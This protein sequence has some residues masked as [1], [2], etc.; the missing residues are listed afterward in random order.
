MVLAVLLVV[1]A[2]AAAQNTAPD[3]PDDPSPADNGDGF[4]SEIN[5]SVSVDDPDGDQLDVYFFENVTENLV[6]DGET[7]TIRDNI[8]FNEIILKS[9][10][11]LYIGDASTGDADTQVYADLVNFSEDSELHLES[12]SPGARLHLCQEENCM[13]PVG[14]HENVEPGG[15]AWAIVGGHDCDSSYD[16]YAT[17]SDGA[18]NSSSAVWSFNVDCN[19]LP[20]ASNPEPPDQGVAPGENTLSDVELSVY[21]SDPD[22]ADDTLTVYFHNAETDS[23]ID[24]TTI[25]EPG[26]AQ[27]VWEDLVLGETYNWFVNVSDG[28]ENFTS[29]SW[30]FQRVTSTGYRAETRIDYDYTSIITSTQ[31][32]AT[33]FIEVENFVDESKDLTTTLSVP[34]GGADPIFVETGTSTNSYTLPAESTRRMEVRIEPSSPGDKDLIV[35]TSND[36]LGITTRE[37]IPLYVRELPTIQSS[38]D[39][40]GIG[41]VHVIVLF[42]AAT[43]LFA[44]SL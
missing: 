11:E 26:T 37:S 29:S 28:K 24:S 12:E 13:K 30:E 3:Q 21:A 35:D 44:S 1:I 10:S 19:Q 40:P 32:A 39:V 43:L 16:W 7:R 25:S 14:K 9:N 33:L 34:Q 17:A 18:A 4:G 15:R 2:S 8:F 41:L 5:L 38:R 20:T 23:L 31:S 27:V 22:D 42:A 36:D 6:L